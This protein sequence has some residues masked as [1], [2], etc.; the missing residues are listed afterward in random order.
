[1]T[2]N[3]ISMMTT[4]R[5]P[6]SPDLLFPVVC[7]APLK[8]TIIRQITIAYINTSMITTDFASKLFG[9]MSPIPK[10]VK[11]V[12]LKII[13]PDRLRMYL[14][15]YSWDTFIIAYVDKWIYVTQ[16][17]LQYCNSSD[18]FQDSADDRSA[19]DLSLLSLFGRTDSLVLL[20]QYPNKHS[21]HY[22]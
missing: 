3:I 16:C 13:C 9:F 14:Y 19:F 18:S 21:T 8:L 12:A 6:R 1:M 11:I 22:S 15:Y 7:I 20:L 10:V 4:S 2:E 5:F 17:W